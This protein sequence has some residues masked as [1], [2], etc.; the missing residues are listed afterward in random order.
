MV[1]RTRSVHESWGFVRFK[2]PEGVP[3]VKICSSG[4]LSVKAKRN[5]K[6]MQKS[7]VRQ[8]VQI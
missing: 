5:L 8:T 1:N 4:S 2:L 6:V 7:C 3:A